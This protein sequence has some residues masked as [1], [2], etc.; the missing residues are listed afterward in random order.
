MSILSPLTIV[1]GAFGAL[2]PCFQIGKMI[3]ERSASGISLPMVAGGLLTNVV[4][5]AYG[6]SQR[7]LELIGPDVVAVTVGVTYLATV[8]ALRA[9][10]ERAH[11]EL[12]F[13]EEPTLI[14][15]PAAA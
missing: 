14:I 6:F 9:R 10:A 3:R 13:S 1:M 8:L 12:P 4:W 5:T 15:L 11:D 2:L 7:K